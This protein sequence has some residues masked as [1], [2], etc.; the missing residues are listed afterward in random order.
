MPK[1]AS[2][3]L[4]SWKEFIIC[5]AYTLRSATSHRSTLN[6]GT[7]LEKLQNAHFHLST[8][9]GEVQ[10]VLIALA[11]KC[12]VCD[13]CNGIINFCKYCFDNRRGPRNAFC[14]FVDFK[15]RWTLTLR[16]IIDAEAPAF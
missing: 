9:T 10:V 3:F 15:R 7:P 6:G 13:K 2:V 4:N 14:V 5:I 12:E 1:R 16:K 8:K 11:Y